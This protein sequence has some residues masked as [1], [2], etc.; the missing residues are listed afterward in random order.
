M[1]R[2][3]KLQ[4]A[5]IWRISKPCISPSRALEKIC[6]QELFH[7]SYTP[8]SCIPTLPGAAHVQRVNGCCGRSY[9]AMGIPSQVGLQMLEPNCLQN[10]KRDRGM[11]PQ[12]LQKKQKQHT[13]EAM[14]RLYL[15]HFLVHMQGKPPLYTVAWTQWKHR[16][17]GGS[18]LLGTWQVSNKSYLS[19]QHDEPAMS[20]NELSACQLRRRRHAENE[21]AKYMS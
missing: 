19:D 5:C 8:T 1:H 2:T 6:T 16:S 7:S 3:C 13:Q 20:C 4:P 18:K 9:T 15:L 11:H 10:K 17:C 21:I 14:Y 12:P